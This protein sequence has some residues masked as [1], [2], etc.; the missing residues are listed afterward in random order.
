MY[1][2]QCGTALTDQSQLCS[3]CGSKPSAPPTDATAELRKTV[4]ASSRDAAEALRTL[5]TDPVLGLPAAFTA[6]GPARAQNAGIALCITFALATAIGITLGAARWFGGLLGSLGSPGFAGFLK[7]LLGV[8]VLPAAFTLAALGI[9]KVLRA[10]P[11][12]ASDIFT[13]GAALLPLGIA[14]LASGV[15]GSLNIEI[16]I[17]LLLFSMSYLV[18][19]LFTGIT[20]LGGL[21]ERAG[22]PAVPILIAVG[23]WISK[24]VLAAL[25]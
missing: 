20:K 18:L 14:V 6:L 7:T 24:V 8:L 16:V 3:G 15:L 22:A 4:S 21:T 5:A 17:L 10:T 11:S 13:A 19:L 12:V 1:C 25:S 2:Q 23:V 9:R